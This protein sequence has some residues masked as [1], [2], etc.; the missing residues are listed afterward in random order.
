MT[1]AKLCHEQKKTQLF[2][3]NGLDF[4]FQYI[5]NTFGIIE[6]INRKLQPYTSI[7][8]KHL[9][10]TSSQLCV[11]YVVTYNNHNCVSN[12]K[13]RIIDNCS[14]LYK[15]TIIR[16]NIFENI[17][18]VPYKHIEK[19]VVVIFILFCPQMPFTLI[20]HKV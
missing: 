4:H 11:R 13:F 1:G 19:Q 16:L 10:K 5:Q 20:D 3:K 17:T 18:L 12:K 14:S 7:F 6:L 9:R 15:T 8:Q 2:G